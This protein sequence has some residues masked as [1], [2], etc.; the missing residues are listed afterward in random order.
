M[1]IKRSN[2][3][4]AILGLLTFSILFFINLK[5]VE[6]YKKIDLSDPFKNYFS[7]DVEPYAVL[8]LSGSNGYPIEVNYAAE[9]GLKVLRSR[10]NHMKHSMHGDTLCIEFTGAS[11]SK[12]QS[13]FSKTAAAIL[14]HRNTLPK[15]IATDIHCRI[16]DFD[17]D[18]LYL[19]LKGHALSEIK[20]CYLNRMKVDISQQ[21]QLE[22]FHQNSIDSLELSM[23]N[24][25]VA[26]L[27]NVN[28]HHITQDLS[29]SV[30]IVLSN[31]VFS[32]L[33]NKPSSI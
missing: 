25:S 5:L 32:T 28:L 1:K 15:I 24:T 8:K 22:F 20:G 4:L 12:Q 29:D 27:K 11:I 7:L 9:N 2:Q 13:Q 21:G 31:H 33:L 14:I 23:A 3:F 6:E 18:Q 26:F 30:S 19:R 10:K 17:T 16:S